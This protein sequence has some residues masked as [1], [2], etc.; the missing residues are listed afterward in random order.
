ML[1]GGGPTLASV[2]GTSWE[3]TA[4]LRYALKKIMGPRRLKQT[5]LL[6]FAFVFCKTA[7]FGHQ[8]HVWPACLILDVSG[9]GRS[10]LCPITMGCRVPALSAFVDPLAGV[11]P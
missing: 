11:L 2:G 5:G 6:L 4:C 9:G 8:E 1:L 10:T 3:L 7:V